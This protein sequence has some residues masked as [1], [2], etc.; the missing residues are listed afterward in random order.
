[1]H[2]ILNIGNKYL[3][4]PQK[5]KDRVYTRGHHNDDHTAGIS[6]TR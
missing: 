3:I 1:M 4:N 5:K 2:V 6:R